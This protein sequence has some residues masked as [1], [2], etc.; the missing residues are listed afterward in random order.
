[1][2]QKDGQLNIIKVWVQGHLCN[3]RETDEETPKRIQTAAAVACCV[4]SRF[5]ER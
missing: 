4:F 5:G 3:Q 2:I 1:M